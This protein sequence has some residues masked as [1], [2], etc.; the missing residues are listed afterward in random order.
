M[1][2][3]SI[4]RRD[5]L[6]RSAA[7]AAAATTAAAFRTRELRANTSSGSVDD[8]IV[9]GMMGT[10]GRGRW[11]IVNELSKRK[12]VEIAYVCDCDQARAEQAAKEVETR[13]GNKPK[14]ADFRKMLEDKR[15]EAVFNCTPDHW[16]A[17]GTIMACQAGKDVYVEKPASHTPWEGRQMVEAARKYE[18]VVQLGTQ[19][20]A[21]PYTI[22]A[23]KFLDAGGIGNVH[24]VRVRNITQ[25]GAV[26]RKP[27]GEPPEGVDYDMWVGPAPL[28]PFNPTRFH[29]NWHWIWD[30]SGGDIIND[31]I[32]QID[33]A[34]YLIGKDYPK[35]V[36]SGGGILARDDAMETP[37]TQLAAWDFGDCIMHFELG[38]WAPHMKKLDWIIRDTDQMPDWQFNAMTIELH[39][40][41]GMMYFERHGGGWQAWDK[42]QKLIEQVAGRHPHTALIDDFFACMRSRSTPVADIQEGHRS[43]LLSQ[44]ANISYRLEGRK[45]MFDAT[46]ETFGSDSQANAF[47]RRDYRAPWVVPEKV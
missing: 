42:D 41:K 23:R 11:L 31:G 35:S 5:F 30:F 39:G 15:V 1:S 2:N 47:L 46:T 45:L 40:T 3:A 20:R 16:H 17:L 36:W 14:I 37:D 28:K 12:N 43:T 44:M 25:R 19:T 38:L 26:P 33:A 29:Y 27:D 8:K 34:R 9:I 18:R 4:S 10:G 32:H 24:L 6:N 22:A 21:G 13:M 7:T